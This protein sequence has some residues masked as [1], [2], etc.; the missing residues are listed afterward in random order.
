MKG[1][2]PIVK[3][4]AATVVF[5]I[6]SKNEMLAKAKSAAAHIPCNPALDTILGVVLPYRKSKIN[7]IAT[8][9][10]SER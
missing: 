5:V 2:E 9:N 7:D 4:V 8:V 3:V 6:A 10:A 1:I